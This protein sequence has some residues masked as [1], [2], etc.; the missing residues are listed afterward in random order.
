MKL[1]RRRELLAKIESSYGTDAAP[2][3]AANAIF[4]SNATVQVDA[5]QVE[6][7]LVRGTIG[8]VGS[9]TYRPRAVVRGAVELAG[10]GTAGTAPKW[11]PLVRALGCSETI[12]AGNRVEYRPVSSNH[13]S[14]TIYFFADGIRHRILGARGTGRMVLRSGEVPRL[15]VELTGRYEAPTD[16]AN[17][18]GIYTG[19]SV[20]RIPSRDDTPTATLHGVTLTTPGIE[21]DINNE[22]VARDLINAKDVLITGREP[23]GEMTVGA[24]AI[25]TVNWHERMVNATTGA[26]SFVHG[27]VAG[28]I[29]ELTAPAVQIANVAE[30]NNGGILYYR[31][32]LAFRENAGDDEFVLIAR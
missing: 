1:W 6:R 25:S 12:V 15:E 26:L 9:L 18:A 23:R 13:D 16:V 7:E 21:V 20:P 17:P 30:A 2:T 22:V 27:T 31:L 3:G 14:L 29:I 10:S 11:G 8:R 28:N 5:D 32:S 19:W 24:V 4:L